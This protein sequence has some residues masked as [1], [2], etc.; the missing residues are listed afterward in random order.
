VL[1]VIFILSSRRDDLA[2]SPPA[3]ANATAWQEIYGLLVSVRPREIL[4]GND[5]AVSPE[6]SGLVLRRVGS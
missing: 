2:V 1:S 5:F 4:P 6:L 3:F